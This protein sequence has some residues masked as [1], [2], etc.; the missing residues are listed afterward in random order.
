L[1]FLV[2]TNILSELR[3]GSRC[4]PGVTSWFAAVSSTDLFLSAL[5][6]GEIRKGIERLRHRDERTA[7]VLEA[8]LHGLVTAYSDR[9]LPVD[10]AIAEQWGRFNG[11]APLPVL[12]S[13]LAATAK[14]HG[15]TVVTRNLKDIKRTGVDCLNPFSA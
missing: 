1:S 10:E 14:V 13:L 15:L 12:D 7:E 9:I 2:D 11:P 5:T 8:W 4:D 3:K 6:L